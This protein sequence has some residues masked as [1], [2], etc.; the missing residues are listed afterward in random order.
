MKLLCQAADKKPNNG[1]KHKISEGRVAMVAMRKRLE[2]NQR[3]RLKPV[4]EGLR[5]TAKMDL[6][7]VKDFT[8]SVADEV[9]KK[10]DDDEDGD[11]EKK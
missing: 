10:L 2:E 8:S 5:E 7:T 3:R 9:L 11:E 6:K 1:I 4:V